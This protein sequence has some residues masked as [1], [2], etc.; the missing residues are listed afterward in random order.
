MSKH[1]LYFYFMNSS[2]CKKIEEYQLSNKQWEKTVLQINKALNNSKE[3]YNKNLI[4][5]NEDFRKSMNESGFFFNTF[6]RDYNINILEENF[7]KKEKEYT[8]KI[9]DM[10]SEN[11]KLQKR[12][13]M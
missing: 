1:L 7:I 12:I 8:K 5:E 6:K 11:I 13:K 2:L 9:Q 10:N 3:E 4:S